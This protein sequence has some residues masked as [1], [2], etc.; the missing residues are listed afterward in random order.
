VSDCLVKAISLASS[1]V[2]MLHENKK[3]FLQ[4]LLLLL[5]KSN[6]IKVLTEIASTLHKWV[7]D[8][9][10]AQNPVRN[11]AEAL[12]SFCLSTQASYLAP[13]GRTPCAR[14]PRARADGERKSRLP[15]QN[16]AIRA[17]K[18]AQAV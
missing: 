17:P 13:V 14:Q 6:D 10:Y 4:Q 7:V 8:D 11:D 15:D 16:D 9:Y 5:D 1:R 3:T 18:R 2:L 12:C